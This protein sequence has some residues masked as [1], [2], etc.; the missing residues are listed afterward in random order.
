MSRIKVN[1]INPFSGNNITLG[2]HAIPSGN[3]KNLGSET[4]AWSELYV[5]TGS[6]NFVAPVTLGQPTVTV[7]S[8]KAG[9]EAG[10][11]GP[12]QGMIFTETNN[13][14]GSF[15]V[16]RNNRALGTA[17]LTIGSTNTSSGDFSLAQ[18][19]GTQASGSVSHAEG[20]YTRALGPY[21]HAEG[22]ATLASIWSKNNCNF[23]W[24]FNK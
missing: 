5:S 6:V 20:G 14:R 19:L 15:S 21:S 2:G 8:L 22:Q 13:L 9:G 11:S 17:S 12:V 3:D 10:V 7:A 16:G 24:Y 23:F 18:G 1:T 4:N